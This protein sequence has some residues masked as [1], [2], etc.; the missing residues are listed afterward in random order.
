MIRPDTSGAGQA[1]FADLHVGR[2]RILKKKVIC[3]AREA[4]VL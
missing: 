3:N 1:D 2:G 4:D